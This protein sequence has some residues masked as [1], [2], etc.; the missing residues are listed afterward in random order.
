MSG[1][2]G[3]RRYRYPSEWDCL[4][5]SGQAG[6]PGGWQSGPALNEPRHTLAACASDRVGVFPQV[7]G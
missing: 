7:W 5:S 2:D 4:R 3:V 6:P 1:G